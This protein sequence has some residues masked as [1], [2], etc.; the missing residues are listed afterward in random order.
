[1]EVLMHAL[2]AHR[3]IR[4][5]FCAPIG[6][7]AKVLNSRIKAWVEARTIHSTLEFTGVFERNADNQ[8]ETDFVVA[9]EQS[10]LGSPL[11][12]ALFDAIPKEAH[13]LML[14][15][16][17]Q[18]APIEPG[19]VL[20]SVLEMELFDHHKLSTTHR[21]KGAIL[22]VVNEVGNGSCRARSRDDVEFVG[23]LPDATPENFAELANQVKAA[24]VKHGGLDRVG[25][26][27]P[28]RKGSATTPG[29]NVTYLNAVLRDAINPDL[30]GTKRVMG[31]NLRIEDRIIVNKN[32][33]IPL[34]EENAATR[35][36]KPAASQPVRK[37]DIPTFDEGGN[38]VDM[39]DE[40]GVAENDEGEETYV[41]NGDTGWL[42]SIEFSSDPKEA[43]KPKNLILR[44][45]DDRRVKFP[46]SE[47]EN[48]NLSYAITVHASQGSEYG[49][50]FAI[51]TDGHKQFMHRAMIF[52]MF[53]RAQSELMIL[54][55]QETLT[56]VVSR[57]PPERNCGLVEASSRLILGLYDTPE[58]K[59][60][61]TTS[62]PRAT[63]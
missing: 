38:I 59:S 16:P 24:A 44:L 15:D 36:P 55:D 10:M 58:S 5:T 30:D 8:L 37:V 12:S 32:M 11:G 52:T 43:H 9:D 33:R 31:T 26:I 48:L 29:W 53:S 18:L 61:S 63:C 3:E 19:R 34:Y 7:A 46:S 1:V 4:S 49:K 13:I 51:V 45:D 23:D 6:K 22:A 20:R 54:G 62:K 21:N 25:V 28:M 17:G 50:V 14:G 56:R 42:E 40:E 27:C 57:L 60:K 47:L 41:V 35:T 39:G 2:H